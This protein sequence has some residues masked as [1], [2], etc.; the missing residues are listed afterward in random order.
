M[1][2]LVAGKWGGGRRPG[3]RCVVGEPELGEEIRGRGQRGRVV[4][5]GPGGGAV[6]GREQERRVPVQG[7]EHGLPRFF[8]GAVHVE[9][10]EQHLESGGF[11][12][13]VRLRQ[14]A[15]GKGLDGLV[16]TSAAAKPWGETGIEQRNAIFEE[17]LRDFL[18]RARGC[19]GE[20][21]A[22]VGSDGRG[23][24][25]IPKA[26]V[27]QIAVVE[28]IVAQ[29]AGAVGD[30]AG[31]DERIGEGLPDRVIHIRQL[32]ESGGKINMRELRHRLDR[33]ERSFPGGAEFGAAIAPDSAHEIGAPGV[34]EVHGNGGIA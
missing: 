14:A 16:G 24:P 5:E 3:R 20:G 12:V 30:A 4:A 10:A 32:R 17:V 2:A 33:H 18:R 13:G 22:A 19:S 21:A 15:V 28:E 26:Q 31:R 8:R 1:P 11:G 29:S 9:R 25:G 6:D 7:T 23:I 34:G 27:R